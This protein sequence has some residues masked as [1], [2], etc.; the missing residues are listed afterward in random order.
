MNLC[1]CRS[2]GRA[3]QPGRPRPRSADISTSGGWAWWSFPSLRSDSRVESRRCNSGNSD[4]PFGAQGLQPGN[5][6][7]AHL[8]LGQQLA[9]LGGDVSER[10]FGG[11]GLLQPGNEL[12]AVVSFDGF[13]INLDGGT[14]NGAP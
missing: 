4:L 1:W 13:G 14:K 2:P 12:V 7:L 5:E 3:R 10:D 11:P 9:N 8:L 6:Q